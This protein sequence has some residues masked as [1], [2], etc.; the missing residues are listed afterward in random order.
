M[1]IVFHCGVHGT[2]GD[3]MLK[4]L[5]NNRDYLLKNGTE[6][7]TPNRYRGVL[8]EALMSLNG[9]TA[10]EEM[11]E[12]LLDSI[13]ETD[14]PHRVILSHPGFQGPAFRALS[15]DGLYPQMGARMRSL[16]ALFPGHDSE[17]FIALRHPVVLLRVLLAQSPNSTYD[18]LT[19]GL[20]PDE[21]S[22]TA[23]IQRLVATLGGRHR[24]VLWC[25]EDVPLIWPEVLR[26][27]GDI[28]PE[29]RL[30]GGLAYLHDV[31]GDEGLSRLRGEMVGRDRLTIAERRELHSEFIGVFATDDA[32]SEP[33]DL[34]GWTQQDVDKAT[35]RYEAD[36]AEIAVLPGVEFITP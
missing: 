16:A 12:I 8:D 35:A 31:I 5:L 30:S 17:F 24:L 18:S 4:S 22:W 23:A 19:R 26:L 20:R 6:V 11:Q 32:L 3:R 21:F 13:L 25:H 33:V 28:P 1:K 29:V 15:A 9:G 27:V 14:S 2:D 10:T 36:I 7:L 34:P